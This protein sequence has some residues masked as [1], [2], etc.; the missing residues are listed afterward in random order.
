MFD[1]VAGGYLPISL[2]ASVVGVACARGRSRIVGFV[3]ATCLPVVV[4]YTW[5]W[6]PRVFEPSGGDSLRPWD[7]VA[8]TMW[9]VAAVPV[10]LLSYAVSR[11]LYPKR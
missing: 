6:I 3:L 4:A 9:S 8:T 10:S 1:S 2:I 11:Y 7:L 5:F